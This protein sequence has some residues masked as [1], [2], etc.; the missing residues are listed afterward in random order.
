MRSWRE[1]LARYAPWSGRR[2]RVLWSLPLVLMVLL[3]LF[4]MAASEVTEHPTYHTFG[5]V[6]DRIFVRRPTYPGYPDYW[7]DPHSLEFNLG[8]PLLLGALWCG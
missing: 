1:N 7:L 3:W 4:G 2:A 5:D 8:Y 6:L